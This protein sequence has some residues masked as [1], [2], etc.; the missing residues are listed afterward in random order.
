MMKTYKDFSRVVKKIPLS[1]LPSES[2]KIVLESGTVVLYQPGYFKDGV[3][4]NR[5]LG[6]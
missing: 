6:E 5:V 1:F 3:F 2:R 4:Y